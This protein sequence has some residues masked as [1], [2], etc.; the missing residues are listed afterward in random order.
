VNIVTKRSSLHRLR[1][2]LAR[3]ELVLGFIGGS[4]TEQASGKNWPEYIISWFCEKFP[5][6]TLR[7]E[8]AAI[9]ATGSEL[10]VFRVDN[11]IIQRGCDIVFVEFAVNDRG[12][13]AGMRMQTR[14]GLIRKLMKADIDVVLTYTFCQ[15]MYAD[16]NNDRV[17]ESIADFDILAENYG[18][19]S[20]WM[21]LYALRELQK[22]WMKW[23][24]WLPDGL[25]PGYRGS[26]S[27]AQSVIGFLEKELDADSEYDESLYSK[28]LPDAV[29]SDNWEQ[30]YTLPLETV[31]HSGPWALR[32]WTQMAMIDQV[33]ETAA[34]GAELSFPFNGRGLALGFDFGRYSAEFSYRIDGGDWIQS[35][36][37]RPSWCPDTGWYRITTLADDLPHTD[38]TFELVV[39]H[40]NTEECQ[41][42]NFRL[43][44]IGV[45]S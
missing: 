14:E 34:V 2:A 24:E 45:I 5:D 19:S 9:G 26:L 23:E 44:M 18:I 7:V 6:L 11:D 13:Q 40:G 25:H 15:E 29:D 4:I 20:I 3:K 21:G 17:P 43:A 37:E 32:R 36:R 38:H 16:M 8:N 35:V 22:G 27:Y 31:Y 42:S 28:L 10:G 41:G 12:M 30:V 1:R 39:R 33:L